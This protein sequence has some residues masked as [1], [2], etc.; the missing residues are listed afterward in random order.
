MRANFRHPTGPFWPNVQGHALTAH[1]A[2]QPISYNEYQQLLKSV[3]VMRGIE[4]SAVLL[5]DLLG[6]QLRDALAFGSMG[7][8]AAVSQQLDTSKTQTVNALIA[9]S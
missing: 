9:N 7:M 4:R 6:K 2:L 3:E 1:S 8:V 5:L